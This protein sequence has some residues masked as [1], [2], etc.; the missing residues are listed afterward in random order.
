MLK[1]EKKTIMFTVLEDT[2]RNS[3]LLFMN[4]VHS[5]YSLII[6]SNAHVLN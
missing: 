6:W 4:D 2:N 5:T 1:R 3:N